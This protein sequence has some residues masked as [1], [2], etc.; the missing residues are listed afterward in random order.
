MIGSWEEGKGRKK[1]KIKRDDGEEEKEKV[2]DYAE[3]NFSKQ[4]QSGSH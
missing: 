2:A 1:I 4:F 3:L